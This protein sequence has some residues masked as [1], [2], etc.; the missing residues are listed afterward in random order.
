[1]NKVQEFRNP[2]E[3]VEFFGITNIFHW[4]VLWWFC[5]SPKVGS[6]EPTPHAPVMSAPVES[7][8]SSPTSSSAPVCCVEC[9]KYWPSLGPEHLPAEQEEVLCGVCLGSV[10]KAP[11]IAAA[12]I[13][14]IRRS[15]YRHK[16]FRI[17]L[18]LPIDVSVRSTAQHLV[19]KGHPPQ[20]LKLRIRKLLSDLISTELGMVYEENVTKLQTLVS[21]D[22]I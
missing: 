17:R 13:Q 7:S 4:Q 22:D 3:P 19:Q 12:I 21:Q 1:M 16:T 10:T 18:N 15:E 8:S 20:T 14:H 11:A 5:K 6:I 9:L 2:L